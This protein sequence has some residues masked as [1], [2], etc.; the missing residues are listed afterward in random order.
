[1]TMGKMSSIN[2]GRNIAVR[3]ATDQAAVLVLHLKEAG[4]N[5]RSLVGGKVFNLGKMIAAGLPVPRGFCV[6]TTAFDHFLASYP[7]RTELS[8]LLAQC[9]GDEIGRF[10][11]LSREVRSCLAEARVPEEVKDAVVSLKLLNVYDGVFRSELPLEANARNH[12]ARE[13]LAAVLDD[14]R[15]DKGWSVVLRGH[16][17]RL[18]GIVNERQNPPVQ[19]RRC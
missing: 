12:E 8:H 15:L 17:L 6:T 3:A 19:I 13:R 11:G 1:M 2:S 9:S 18:R 16:D 4:D 7:G 5:H 14:L 10:A